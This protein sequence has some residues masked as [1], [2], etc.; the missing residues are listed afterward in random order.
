MVGAAF[1]Y[2]SVKRFDLQIF[3]KKN[4]KKFDFFWL[5]V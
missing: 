3:F 5:K 1:E 2:Q 4:E